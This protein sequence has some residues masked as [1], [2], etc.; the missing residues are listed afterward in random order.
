MGEWNRSI[1][2]R[3]RVDPARFFVDED[4]ATINDDL[5]ANAQRNFQFA[6]QNSSTEI[7]SLGAPSDEIPFEEFEDRRDFEEHRTALVNHFHMQKNYLGGI[8]WKIP[9]KPFVRQFVAPRFVS[10]WQTATAV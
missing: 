7:S 4:D 2:A 1:L 6:A 10:K 8:E 5:S 3:A 9:P